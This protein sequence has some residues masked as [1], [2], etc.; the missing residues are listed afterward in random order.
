MSANSTDIATIACQYLESLKP[1]A[2]RSKRASYFIELLRTNGIFSPGGAC[3]TDFSSLMNHWLVFL[4]QIKNSWVIVT[5]WITSTQQDM[6]HFS[7]E[8]GIKAIQF[9]KSGAAANATPH[10][11]EKRGSSGSNTSNF[12]KPPQKASNAKFNCAVGHSHQHDLR[13]IRRSRCEATG[14]VN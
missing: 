9:V 5:R 1:K 14:A 8:E 7:Y 11:T 12:A 10:K 4:E 6:M 2:P 13:Q 3:T